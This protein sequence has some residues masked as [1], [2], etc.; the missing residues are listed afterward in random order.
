MPYI[1]CIYIVYQLKIIQ[2]KIIQKEKKRGPFI[3]LVIALDNSGIPL[4]GFPTGTTLQ[5]Y[6][7]VL[8]SINSYIHKTKGV[9]TERTHTSA[10]YISV[11]KKNT[12]GLWN[13][14]AG[15]TH[16]HIIFNK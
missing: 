12:N 14:L 15:P 10:F 13:F 3:L 16:H 4:H 8:K 11:K 2:N 6:Y 5:S 9:Q 1:P 7:I